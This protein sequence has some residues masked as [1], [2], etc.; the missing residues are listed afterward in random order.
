M[1]IPKG[2]KVRQVVPAIEGEVMDRRLNDQQGELEYCVGFT[3][4]GG[5]P[6]ERWFLESQIAVVE[7]AA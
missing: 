6:G 1:A 3:D 5:E 2:T 4:A 7:V